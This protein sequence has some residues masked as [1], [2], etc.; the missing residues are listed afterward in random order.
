MY[1][2]EE[3]EEEDLQLEEDQDHGQDH[4]LNQEAQLK[5]QHL[6]NQNL[7]LKNQNHQLENQD[8][9]LKN[10]DHQKDH[11]LDQL[12]N[13]LI[14]QTNIGLKIH[15]VLN[16]EDGLVKNVPLEH[17]LEKMENVLIQI[18]FVKHSIIMMDVAHLVMLDMILKEE[19]VLLIQII[20]H[21]GVIVKKE[22]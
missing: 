11:I 19:I 4:Q 2:E 13:H 21:G 17:I 12:E 16:G 14:P 20:K 9:Q 6:Q 10:Q 7:Q 5:N 15:F 22:V 1:G 18:H 8:H 3:E